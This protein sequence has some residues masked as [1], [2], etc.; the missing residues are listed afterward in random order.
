MTREKA[1]DKSSEEPDNG[2]SYHRH[3]APVMRTTRGKERMRD[4][5]TEDQSLRK[6]FNNQ[7]AQ[8]TQSPRHGDTERWR[9]TRIKQEGDRTRHLG[10]MILSLS[11]QRITRSGGCRLQCESSQSVV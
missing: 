6:K 5:R 9:R 10:K 1:R 4:H 7:Q 3:L 11:C 8:D 2:G